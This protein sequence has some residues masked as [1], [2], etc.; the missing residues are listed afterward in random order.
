VE[1]RQRFGWPLAFTLVAAFL[2]LA[3]LYVFR[4]LRQVPADVADSGVKLVREL[5]DLARAFTTGTVETSFHSYATEVHGSSF[6]QFATLD[7]MEVFERSDHTST[8]WG[9]L[10]LPE[11]VVRATAPVQYTYYLDLDADW[12]FELE[13]STLRV[14]APGIRFNRPAVDASRLEYE[15]RQGSVFRDEEAALESLRA[16]ISA[17]AHRRAQENVPLVRE[18]GRRRTE[19][20][21]AGWLLHGFDQEAGDYRIEVVFA[22]EESLPRPVEP[23]RELPGSGS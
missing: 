9:Q 22:G 1:T 6:L 5:G 17:M 4:S 2:I 20:F 12:R 18:I 7:E 21:V 15:V 11:V 14:R 13:G 3:G 8:L 19:D 10:M 16:G 23:A